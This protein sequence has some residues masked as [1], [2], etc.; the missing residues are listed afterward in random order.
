MNKY[1]ILYDLESG[2]FLKEN[3]LETGGLTEAMTRMKI[4][5][6]RVRT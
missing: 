3:H 4:S 6:L 1:P 5:F 2:I